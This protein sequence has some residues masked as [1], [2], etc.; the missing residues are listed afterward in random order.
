MVEDHTNPKPSDVVN[1]LCVIDTRKKTV[2]NI[3]SGA[4][5]YSTPCFAPDGKHIAWQQWHHPDMP[6]EGC[7]ICVADVATTETSLT[8]HNTKIVAGKPTDVSAA[9]PQW[10]TSDLLLFLSDV[11]DYYNPWKYTLST[12]AAAPV[13]STPVA[14]DFA[15]PQWQLSFNFGCVLDSEGT[16]AL[17]AA[18]RGGRSVLYA[19]SIPGGTLAELACPF[20]AVSLVRRVTRDAVVLRAVPD[21][22]RARIVLCSI[23]D[24]AR[25]TY[26]PLGAGEG[27][28]DEFAKL[29]PY[30]SLPRAMALTAPGSDE[31]VH[32]LYYPP[33]N[34]DCVAPLGERPPAVFY[35]HG[36]PTSAVLQG[37]S[38]QRTYYTSR[39][40]AWYASPLLF[41]PGLRTD[42]DRAQDWGQLRR[43]QRV[44]PQVHVSA[45]CPP[46]YTRTGTRSRPRRKRLQGEWGVVDVRDCATAA[47]QLAAG[48]GALV[49]G[50]RMAITGGS[51]GGYT[52]L[53]ALCD[54][55]DVFA[56]GA[57]SYGISNLFKLAEF[58]HKFESQ[59]MFKLVGGTPEDVPEVY[60]ARSPVFHADK[61]KSPLLVSW[62]TKRGCGAR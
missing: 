1:S 6:W 42:A 51:A 47:T 60:K 5:F 23:A 37:L 27:A 45:H 26:T 34:P 13:L 55:P 9:Y 32:V 11:S 16:T 7:E 4:D 22:E 24:Y 40:Y 53:Q 2:T 46:L 15:L 38:W 54:A 21:D 25:P 10:A 58:T 56:A 20:A 52:V 59:Y 61:I 3:V 39:G 31:P 29:K 17:Y 14:E 8:V 48:P 12:G 19:V 33:T 35:S 30:V 18:L 49:D 50:R 28:D 44:R 41:S 36:G 57:A 62:A 43:E